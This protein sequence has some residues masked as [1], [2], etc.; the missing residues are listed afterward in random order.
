MS[1]TSVSPE[2]PLTIPKGKPKDKKGKKKNLSASQAAAHGRN[3]GVD[4]TWVYKPPPGVVL[5]ETDEAHDAGGFEWDAVADNPDLELWLIRVPDAVRTKSTIAIFHRGKTVFVIGKTEIPRKYYDCA[6]RI[7]FEEWVRG[8]DTS[9]T[10]VV[11]YLVR[12]G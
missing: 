10:H 3:E 5:L 12:W 9:Q 2:P 6:S 8:S 7:L 11:R 4:P 1:S